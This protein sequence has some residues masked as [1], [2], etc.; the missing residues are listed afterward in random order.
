MVRRH[1]TWSLFLS[2]DYEKGD[3][4]SVSCTGSELREG[5]TSAC[6]VD[7]TDLTRECNAHNAFG[8][9]NA[10]PC[11]LL[12]LNRVRKCPNLFK[13]SILLGHLF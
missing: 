12:K 2:T 5:E 4:S 3:T 9:S 1:Q 7:F 11:V 8:M 10:E 6:S 13:M